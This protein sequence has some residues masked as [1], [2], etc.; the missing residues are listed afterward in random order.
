[1]SEQYRDRLAEQVRDALGDF[2]DRTQPVI[3]LVAAL[4]AA[5]DQERADNERLRAFAQEM[6][7]EASRDDMED[8]Y[9]PWILECMCEHGLLDG[10]Y[11]ATAL[12]L[13]RG[14]GK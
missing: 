12:L 6:R 7:S 13:G 3:V 11:N 10:D 5:L 9:Q 2:D 8:V 14:E 1:M 4:R